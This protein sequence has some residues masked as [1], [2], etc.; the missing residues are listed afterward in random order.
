MNKVKR[1][2]YDNLYRPNISGLPQHTESM[3]ARKIPQEAKEL[4]AKYDAE[5]KRLDQL[6]LSHANFVEQHHIPIDQLG[7]RE[8]FFDK[9]EELVH[10]TDALLGPSDK[11]RVMNHIRSDLQGKDPIRE[12]TPV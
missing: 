5:Q 8:R 6:K 12:N 4:Q 10:D 1:G 2:Q 3:K 7:K 9:V 11:A